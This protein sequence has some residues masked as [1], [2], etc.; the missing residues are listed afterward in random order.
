MSHLRAP[1]ALF[2]VAIG[3]ATLTIAFAIVKAKHIYVGGLAWPFISDLGRGGCSSN[4]FIYAPASYVFFFGLST[5]GVLLGLAWTFNHE[6]QHRVLQKSYENGQISECTHSLSYV[7]C[8]FGVIGAIGLPLF[9]SF[10]TSPA[11][12]ETTA[13][14][15]LATEATAMYVDVKREELDTGVFITDRDGPRSVYRIKSEELRS[16]QHGFT[17]ELASISVFTVS[18]LVYLP[19]LYSEPPQTHLTIA[20]CL[21]KELGTTYCTQTVRLDATNTRLWSYENALDVNQVRALAQLFCVLALLTY[22]L[23]FVANNKCERESLNEHDRIAAIAKFY[24][25]QASGGSSFNSDD[26]QKTNRGRRTSRSASPSSKQSTRSSPGRRPTSP[27]VSISMSFTYPTGVRMAT[28]N[29]EKLQC[30]RRRQAA[31]HAA[32]QCFSQVNQLQTLQNQSDANVSA[33]RRS[34]QIA[35]LTAER[36]LEESAQEQYTVK[37]RL[38][39]EKR[40]NEQLAHVMEMSKKAQEQ[41]EREVQRICEASEELCELETLLKTA[42]MNRERAV[43]HRQDEEVVEYRRRVEAREVQLKAANETKKAHEDALFKVVEAEIQA[44]RKQEEEIEKLRDDLWEEEMLQKKR[45]QEED[46]MLA[47]QRAKEDMMASNAMQMKLRQELVE[48][49]QAEEDAF[50]VM[51][52]QKFQSEAR[53]DMELAA[54]KRKQKEQYKEEIARHDALK[55]RMV[56]EE[57]QRELQEREKECKRQIV[58]QAKQRLL[59]EHTEV[60]QGYLP[61]NMRPSLSSS[62]SSRHSAFR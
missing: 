54:F 12:H 44:K 15:F 14:V 56:Y 42:Y 52:K 38:L 3:V 51:L 29:V 41:K 47:K 36:M 32:L 4:S 48:R 23:S 46:K 49:Q 26:K 60:L 37:Q 17:I 13:I 1:V 27:I 16:L 30:E 6:Y 34:N 5:V 18:V 50:N 11:I 24:A 55:Q 9:A 33:K 45:Q 59:Q 35:Q 19:L 31:D 62:S 20:E 28:R 57:L 2:V 43:Q 25:S 7:S 8:V 21:A 58:E 22:A 39:R 53:R 61:R 10:D 40:Q